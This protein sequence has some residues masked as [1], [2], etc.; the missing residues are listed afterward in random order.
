MKELRRMYTVFI[1]KGEI[2]FSYK[3]RSMWSCGYEE[4]TL[5]TAKEVFSCGE[6][7]F[8]PEERSMEEIYRMIEGGFAFFPV[9]EGTKASDIKDYI[10]IGFKVAFLRAGEFKKFKKDY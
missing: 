6:N 2:V 1:P 4:R 5:G 9:N 8:T 10:R 3:V 7:G